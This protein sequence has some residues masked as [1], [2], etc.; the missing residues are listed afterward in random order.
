M[1]EL[2]DDLIQRIL[3]TKKESEFAKIVI[4]EKVPFELWQANSQIRE[5]LKSLR[6]N[7]L[8]AGVDNVGF[9]RKIEKN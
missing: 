1:K 3:D 2:S 9:L 6:K 7:G 5:H 4:G 8:Q